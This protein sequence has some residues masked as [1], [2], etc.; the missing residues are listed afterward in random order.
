MAGLTVS[1]PTRV[2]AVVVGIEHY[3][4]ADSGWD[5]VGA[6]GDAVRFARWL[7]QRGVPTA[8]IT[9]LLAAAPDSYA[10]LNR[11]AGDIGLEPTYV[12]S[13]DRIMDHFMPRGT[14]PEGDVLYV[15][16]GGHGVLDHGNR[17]LLLCPDASDA[18]Q[19]CIELTNLQEYLTG[20]D[21]ARFAQQVFLVDACARFIEHRRAEGTPGPAQAAF[22]AGRRET[23]SQFT[24]FAAAA[25]QVAGQGRVAA[26]S[27]DFSTVVTGWLEE[28][29][30]EL[31]PDLHALVEHVKER[32]AE[33][34]GRLR[35]R[36]QT[37]VSLLVQP[38]GGSAEVITPHRAAAP[39]KPARAG[40]RGASGLRAGVLAGGGVLALVAMVAI[41]AMFLS[42][43]GGDGD[44]ARDAPAAAPPP[45]AAGA[46]IAG[47]SPSASASASASPSAPTG[48]APAPQKAVAPLPSAPGQ[49]CGAEHSTGVSDVM[50]R[51]CFVRNGGRI[52]MRAYVRATS[53]PKDV[54]VNL[55]LVGP[56][57]TYVLPAGGPKTWSLKI[58]GEP[59]LFE[60]PIDTGLLKSGS[61]Y[62]VHIAT[63]DGLGV[64]QNATADPVRGHSMPFTY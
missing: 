7:R 53:L 64:T 26:G 57:G 29:S 14:A 15:Y 6:C 31:D 55:W 23:V 25:G 18:D 43:T 41:V 42:K 46:P 24:L 3:P 2:H 4:R 51:V 20:A 60:A 47:P 30:P 39:P 10:A 52:S 62:E 9:L 36:S 54:T 44:A 59:Q 35:G 32:F 50:H 21:V 11:A 13:R 63:R 40:G 56:K 45:A 58:G 49:S 5:L 61:E 22:P 37:P 38:L 19:R 34:E 8:N 17:R 28:H 1:D 33:Q 27:G 12:S 48:A 16:W